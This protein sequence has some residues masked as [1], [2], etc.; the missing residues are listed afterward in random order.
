MQ[1]IIF[2][3]AILIFLML[4]KQAF[5][6]ENFN[7]DMVATYKADSNS[8]MNINYRIAI[9]NKIS[10]VLMKTYTFKLNNMSANNLKISSSTKITYKIDDSGRDTTIVINFN[11]PLVG[12][13]VVQTLDIN[14]DETNLITR[15]GEVWE[16]AIPRLDINN[17]YRSYYTSVI[18][19]TSYG[20]EAYVSPIPQERIVGNDAT[21]YEFTKEDIASYGVSLGFGKFQVYNLEL[22]YHLNN[23]SWTKQKQSISIPPDTAYQRIYIE[24]INPAP[25]N[26]FQDRDGNWLAEYL[27]NPKS[28]LN[29]KV[30]GAAQVF[31]TPRKLFTPEPIAVIENTKPSQ[32][33]Q[34]DN[35]IIKD[36][37]N[38]LKTPE[39]VFKYVTGN[40]TYNYS[41]ANPE[42]SRL[43]ALKALK[44]KDQ[45]LCSEFTDLF[46]ALARASGIPAREI[47]GFAQST[48]PKLQPVSLL[49]DILHAWPEYYNSQSKSWTPID[50]TWTSTSGGTDY[51]NKF[52]LNHITF[53]IHGSDP[54]LPYPPGSS[55]SS[56]NPKKDINVTLGTLPDIRSAHVNIEIVPKNT[57]GLL[58]NKYKVRVSNDGPVAI[59]QNNLEIKSG[60]ETDEPAQNP[61][62]FYYDSLLPNQ[63]IEHKVKI[64]FGFLGTK[65]PENLVVVF[66]SFEKVYLIDNKKIVITQL[67][68]LFIIIILFILYFLP[69][70]KLLS[71]S[72]SLFIKL[73]KDF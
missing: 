49:N 52:D 54:S 42:S 46:I 14:F 71:S 6:S 66:G 12:K 20:E 23:L 57:F 69:P 33:W 40:L 19:P 51:F 3:L 37:S 36:I 27:I 70:K 64:P 47:N 38:S 9:E 53:V 22:D 25:I 21:I 44:F 11:N 34:S 17:K 28:S 72:R 5:A 60:L 7:L 1:K 15:S 39:E 73:K 16:I 31:S 35:D 24:N 50:P 68:L 45:A 65:T 8:I 41:R 61:E 67:L 58:T 62:I 32:Y 29:I 59:Y 18:V 55:F 13:G 63:T 4:P 2:I 56:T 10:E 48:D 43:G 26:V 30:K